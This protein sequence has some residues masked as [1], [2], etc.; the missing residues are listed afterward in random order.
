MRIVVID[1]HPDLGSFGDPLARAYIDGARSGG[2]AVRILRLRE[3]AFDPILH[4]G[5][6]T[7]TPFEPDLLDA[8]EA[9]RWCQHLVIVTPCW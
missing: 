9:I 7:P 6:T 1:G 4:G 2:H 8:R 3:M 5:F